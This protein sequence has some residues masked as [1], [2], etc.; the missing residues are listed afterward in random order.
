[1][2][3]AKFF[4]YILGLLKGIALVTEFALM[5]GPPLLLLGS[6]AWLWKTLTRRQRGVGVVRRRRT[7]GDKVKQP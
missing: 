7:G 4:Q 3:D 6:L 1:V 5:V 2:N